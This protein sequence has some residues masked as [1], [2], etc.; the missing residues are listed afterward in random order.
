MSGSRA[1]RIPSGAQDRDEGP[2]PSGAVGGAGDDYARL[3]PSQTTGLGG[4]TGSG[5]RGRP[6][7]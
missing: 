7:R 2:M 6:R 1:S 3:F 5:G 4:G